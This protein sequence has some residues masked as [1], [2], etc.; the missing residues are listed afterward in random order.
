MSNVTGLGS[1]LVFSGGID[2]T[3]FRTRSISEIDR[4]VD[5]LDDTA[6][7]SDGFY[8]VVPD[9]LKR[10]DPF[11]VEIYYEGVDPPIG[12]VGTITLTFSLTGSGTNPATL[13]GSGFIARA[14]TPELVAGGRKIITIQ[15]RFDGKTGPT[16]QAQS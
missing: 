8:E 5:E 2:F 10:V 9:D 3:G 6:L 15:V 16:F 14:S 7:N 4:F 12:E 11:D 13:T 1:T